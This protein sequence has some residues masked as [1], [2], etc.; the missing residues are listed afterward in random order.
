MDVPWWLDNL[1]YLTSGIGAI[2]ADFVLA[3]YPPTTISAIGIIIVICGVVVTVLE[4]MSGET[5]DDES[6]KG[7]GESE[8]E[9]FPS[10][11]VSKAT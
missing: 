6:T 7:G 9:I 11:G 1:F 5:E 8:A 10:P 4:Y 3:K 2:A